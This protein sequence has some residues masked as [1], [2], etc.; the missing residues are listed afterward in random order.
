MLRPRIIPCLLVR[1]GGL[2]KTVK[3]GKAKYVGDPINA[4]K[5]FN[6]KEVDEIIVLD[7]D[8][9]AEGRDPDYGMI[10]NLA[11]ECRMPLCYGGG[12]RT[13]E[14]VERIIGLGVE[15]VSMSSAVTAD[16]DLITRAAEVVG[17]QSVVVVMDVKK[18]RFS[19]K[20]EIYT[21][22]GKKKASLDPVAF[23]VKAEKLGAGEIVLN[24]IDKDGVMEGYDVDLVGRV[25]QSTNLPMTVLGGAGTLD[26]IKNLIREHGIIGAAAG[27][28][29]VFKGVYRAVLINYPNREEKDALLKNLI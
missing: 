3:F 20:Y 7:I 10:K 5:I 9:T 6:E 16:P 25:R 26:D 4:V 15:K 29:F 28:L 21:H 22:N 24:A 17:A 12:V 1:N 19:R 27:S 13:V 23:A 11:T 8:A 18:G 2:V 14:Q